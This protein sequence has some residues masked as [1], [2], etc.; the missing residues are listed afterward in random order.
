MKRIGVALLGGLISL[1]TIFL[2]LSF[3]NDVTSENVKAAA[4]QFVAP[5]DWNLIEDRLREGK[6]CI[7]VQCPS[8]YCRWEVADIPSA[9]KLRSL[10]EQAGWIDIKL[11][12]ECEPRPNRTGAIPICQASASANKLSINIS[13]AGSSISPDK[14]VAVTLVVE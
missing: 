9:D 1:L 4:D 13:V 5:A 6:G 7:D 3:G 2:L 12:G 8:I 10:M 11:N 14:P